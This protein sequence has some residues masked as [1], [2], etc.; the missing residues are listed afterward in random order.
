M[1]KYHK[2][3]FIF[4]FYFFH[5]VLQT[6]EVWSALHVEQEDNIG[7]AME[8]FTSRCRKD[9]SSLLLSP[10]TSARR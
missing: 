9:E 5:S 1:G 3:F 4:N 7:F 8:V 6:Q 10:L 2:Q